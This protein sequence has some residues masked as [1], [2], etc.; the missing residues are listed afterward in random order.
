MSRANT[1]DLVGV[2]VVVENTRR[3]LLLS[4]KIFRFR[5]KEGVPLSQDWLNQVM[6]SPALREQIVKGATGTSPTMKNISKE[7][8]LRLLVP[9]H[10]LRRQEQIAMET[11]AL[12]KEAAALNRLLHQ[13]SSETRRTATL[14]T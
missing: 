7:K 9:P 11:L 12:G 10:D 5:F 14:D 1:S 2:C 13:S 8:V 6:K 4:D 3:K